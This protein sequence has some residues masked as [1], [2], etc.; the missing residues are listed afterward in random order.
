MF[1]IEAITIRFILVIVLI[2]GLMIPLLLVLALVD[3]RQHYFESAVDDVAQSWSGRQ[4]IVGPIL[5]IQTRLNADDS[6][7]ALVV[8]QDLLYMPK[9]LTVEHSSTHEM[10]NRGIHD[11]PVFTATVNSTAEFR[12]LDPEQIEGSIE[13]IAVVVGISDS[14]GVRDFSITWNDEELGVQESSQTRGVGN[15]V[16]VEL[17]MDALEGGKVD[18]QFM[19]RGTSRFSVFPVGESSEITMNSDWPDPSFDG[20]FL[21]DHRE[22]TDKGF[23][24]YWST[25]ALSRGFPG[26]LSSREFESALSNLWATSV[27]GNDIGYS[28]LKLNTPYRSMERCAKYG[29]LIIV[30]TLVGI[31]C[32]ELI[33]KA[34]FHIIQYGVVGA[35]L[36]LFFLTV[37]SLSE[38]IGFGLGY[39]GAALILSL[40]T[41]SYVWFATKDRNATIVMATVL[42]VLYAALYVVLQLNEYALLVGTVFLLILLASLMFATRSLRPTSKVSGE[43]QE[44]GETTS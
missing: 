23:N 27:K 33:S 19:L 9:S 36:I 30:L 1:K 31:V 20:R 18:V 44:S 2:L 25:H 40:M 13:Q 16:L 32:L 39:L 11:I 22:V 29:S 5:L 42:S 24:A 41:V 3:E 43:V 17:G 15:S 21:P 7:S 4:S 37:L 28:I 8:Q 34:K 10:R 14:R 35:A 12:A 6:Q 38:H 26:L